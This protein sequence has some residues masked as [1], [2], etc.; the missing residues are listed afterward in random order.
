MVFLK[1]F[2][3]KV[4]FEKKQQ[5][6]KK[7]EKM[8]REQKVKLLTDHIS[9]QNCMCWPMCR[10]QGI[11]KL[12]SYDTRTELTGDIKQEFLIFFSLQLQST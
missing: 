12:D 4:D 7:H 10:L 8:P 1:E 3:E 2:F 5:M 9:Y 11:N 6:T